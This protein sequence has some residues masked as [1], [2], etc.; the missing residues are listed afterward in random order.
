MKISLNWLKDYVNF[1]IPPEKLAHQLTMAGL[2]VEKI[3]TV[4]DDTV[5]ELEITPNRPD[6]LNMIGLAREVAAI[7]NRPLRLP[8]IKKI[9]FP[10]ESCA[11]TILDKQG[12]SRYIGTVIQNVAVRNSPEWLLQRLQAIGTRTINN[13][14]DIT[15]FCLLETGQPL[16]AFDCDK[17]IG[18]KIIV[19]RARDGEKIVTI[20]GVERTLNSSV[21]VIADAKRPVAIAGIMGGKETEVTQDTKN[22][23]LESAYFDPVLIRRA[24][25]SLGLSSD[26]SYRFERGVDMNMVEGGS[27]RAIFLIH[28]LAG[29][30]IVQRS[31]NFPTKRMMIQRQI[32]VSRN[33]IN[34]LLGASMTASRCKT[35]LKK[36]DFKVTMSGREILKVTPPFF[37]NDV[38]EEVDIVEEIARI[39]GYEN[40][41]LSLPQIKMMNIK[42]DTKRP[43]ERVIRQTL[44]GLGFDEAITYTMIDEG[45]LKKSHVNSSSVVRVKNPL[46]KDQEIMRPSLLPSLLSALLTN[47]NRGQKNIKLFELGKVYVDS[48]EIN[49]LSLIMT[50][51]HLEDWRQSKKDSLDFYDIKGVVEQVIK[52]LGSKGV[53]FVPAQQ[54]FLVKGKS[55]SIKVQE[56]EIGFLGKITEDVLRHWDIKL[57]EI[58]YAQINVKE[59][60]SKI[61]FQRTYQPIPEFPSIVRDV[62]LAVKTNTTFQQIKELIQEQKPEFLS[63]VEFVEQYVGDKIPAG[64]RGMTFSLVYQLPSRTLREDEVNA[65]HEKI[66][67]SLIENLGA[68]RR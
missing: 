34:Q 40:L 1:T 66:C 4:N 57:K 30:T 50:T 25:R 48:Q 64:H 27:L 49:T 55:A 9:R 62:S 45:S 61:A 59:L 37:R 6:C 58:L 7:L 14:V 39:L 43:L 44:L 35:V 65:V 38:K 15:N 51:P 21:L 47:F 19:R 28:E 33:Q 5:F 36:L 31:D 23:L 60:F 56:R 54:P 8:K 67:Q 68:I 46:T 17:L 52:R 10:R 26:S 53:I 63:S 42:I 29:G 18:G 22:I 32:V 12:C 2:E 24:A 16:H 20:D 13:V 3:E 11:I 41:P